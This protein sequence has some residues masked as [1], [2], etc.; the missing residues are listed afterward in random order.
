MIKLKPLA[1]MLAHFLNLKK[2]FLTFIENLFLL[3][4]KYFSSRKEKSNK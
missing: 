3:D 1:L 4:S 2:N